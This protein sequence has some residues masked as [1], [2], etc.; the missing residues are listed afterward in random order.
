MAVTLFMRKIVAETP[1]SGFSAL[2]LSYFL[3]AGTVLSV[4]KCVQRE[5][6]RMAWHTKK[7]EE[8]FVDADVAVASFDENSSID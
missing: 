8:E 1:L 6:F 5:K 7:F 4:T 3:V 2:S